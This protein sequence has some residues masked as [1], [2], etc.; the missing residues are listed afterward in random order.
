MPAKLI[1]K[2]DS[3]KK[4][5]PRKIKNNFKKLKHMRRNNKVLSLQDIANNKIAD[6]RYGVLRTI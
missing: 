5:I 6:I 3:A 2:F 1:S 4:K